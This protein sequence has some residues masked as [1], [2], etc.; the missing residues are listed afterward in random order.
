LVAENP[1]V[2]QLRYDLALTLLEMGIH[3]RETGHP[4]TA[5]AH[6][7]EADAIL[8]TLVADN[9][10]VTNCQDGSARAPDSG[11]WSAAPGQH[12]PLKRLM[13]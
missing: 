10:S 5:L 2:S 4:D 11:S 9:P 1:T 6:Y 8:T 7:A 13:V 3:R 12:G